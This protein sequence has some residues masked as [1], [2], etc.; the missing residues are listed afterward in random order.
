M[1]VN[2]TIGDQIFWGGFV[3]YS[4]LSAVHQDRRS[5]AS[6]PEAFAEFH[7]ETSLI[8]FAAVLRGRQKLAPGEIRWWVVLL[9]AVL[10]A[11]LR[12]FH[13]TWIGGF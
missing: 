6:G 9:A 10:T 3:V 8:P 2:P 4:W 13:P 1:L 12:F 7:D 5:L 11:L